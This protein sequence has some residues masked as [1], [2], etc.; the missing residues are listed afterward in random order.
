MLCRRRMSA[1]SPRSS[2][3][4]VDL[5]LAGLSA[6]P[7]WRTRGRGARPASGRDRAVGAGLAGPSAPQ[8]AGDH[9]QHDGQAGHGHAAHTC[10]EKMKEVAKLPIADPICQSI[11]TACVR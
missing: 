6:F 3:S 10:G 1:T 5:L 2:S 11:L 8:G 7:A 9:E 4:A